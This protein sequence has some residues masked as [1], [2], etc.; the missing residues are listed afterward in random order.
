[1]KTE[2][3][4]LAEND[5]PFILRLGEWTF[6][7]FSYSKLWESAGYLDLTGRPHGSKVFFH[8]I[9]GAK[10]LWESHHNQVVLMDLDS[11]SQIYCS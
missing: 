5:H 2:C 9:F 8:P 11:S 4:I 1:M 7:H 10:I 6:G 3:D